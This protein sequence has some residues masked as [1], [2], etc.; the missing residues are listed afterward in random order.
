MSLAERPT[1]RLFTFC[2]LYVAQG[3]P[4]GFMAI[5]LPSYL[6]KQ[7][8][9]AA[10][11]GT[12][13]A[14]TTLPFTFKWIWGPIIDTVTIRRFGRRRPW[15]IFAQGMMAVTVLA[16]VAIPSL[17]LEIELL[18]WMILIHTVFN[19]LQDVA[20]DAL[21]VDLL[22]EEERGRANGYMYGSKYFGGIVGGF[23][24]ASLIG[25]VGM[26]SALLAQ[27]A[28]LVAIMFV[29]LFLKE[30]EGT[31]PPSIPLATLARGLGQA[32]SLRSTLV[33]ALLVLGMH[34]AIGVINIAG[35][36]LFMGELA[37]TPAEYTKLTGLWALAVG[38]I[39]AGLT[40]RLGDRFGR[41]KIAVIGS[42]ALAAG[43]VV[44]ALARG[45]W[46]NPTF[47]Y[48]LALYEAA[49][50]G[51]VVVSVIA[52]CMDLSWTKIGG[53]Q[54]AAY[55][56][57]SNF[58]TTLGYQFGAKALSWWEIEGVYLVAAGYQ[59]AILALLVPIDPHQTRR[60]LNDA[61]RINT[62]GIAALLALVTF[63]VGMTVYV[64]A[65]NLGYI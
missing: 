36:S 44:F 3:I 8:L 58:S 38:G 27:V 1:L 18:A 40:G 43:W 26:R 22:S 41:R 16:I 14:F 2:L 28:V 56:A 15:I 65:K 45:A 33:A 32:F 64:T 60:E 46:G 13:L 52:L 35:R 25:E 54:F 23:G 49:A 30:R 50:Q 5:T 19:A 37:W 47:V 48:A 6:T 20:V 24:M 9:D 17:T 21:A 12:A 34:F 57:L 42:C 53:S 39:A 55:M 63:L 62:I 31:A 59:V 29:P 61:S 4:W 10:V 7:G 51:V 11:V